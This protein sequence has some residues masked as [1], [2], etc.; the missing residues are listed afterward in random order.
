MDLLD[1]LKLLFYDRAPNTLLME[2][3]TEEFPEESAQSLS[4]ALSR[5]VADGF[6]VNKSFDNERVPNFRR[7]G[8]YVS[9]KYLQGHPIKTTI[10]V[11][12][13]AIPR[14]IDGDFLHG[15]DLNLLALNFDRIVSSKIR[16]LR[17]EFE[18]ERRRYWATMAT[19]F[20]VFVAVFSLVN[21]SVKPIYYADSLKLTAKDILWQST[22]NFGPLLAVLVVIT[23]LLL[24]LVLK[25]TKRQ[26]LRAHNLQ[27]ATYSKLSTLL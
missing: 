19:L 18:Q 24:L 23:I 21:L 9:A 2:Y 4:E 11:G 13:L 26:V 1:R 16:E 14:M 3:L 17:A 27:F 6:L 25:R 22:L 8:Y 20:G 12:S 15:E 7:V 5:L 10:Q